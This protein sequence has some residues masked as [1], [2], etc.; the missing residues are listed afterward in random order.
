MSIDTTIPVSGVTY[1]GEV[2]PLASNIE[3]VQTTGTSE[4]AVMSQKAVTDALVSAGGSSGGLVLKTKTLGDMAD[5]WINKLSTILS[6]GISPIIAITATNVGVFTQY[7]FVYEV[8]GGTFGITSKNVGMLP[9][10][11]TYYFKLDYYKSGE[12][13]FSC[14][15]GK[16]TYSI[17]LQNGT[18]TFMAYSFSINSSQML[19]TYGS[20]PMT[21]FTG[22]TAVAYYYDTEE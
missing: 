17:L 8:T 12:A 2:M 4:T 20:K 10:G 5:T 9:S 19:Q 18:F 14:V 6:K 1:N 11:Y 3:V 7:S 16:T 13:R 22:E 15:N 21:T